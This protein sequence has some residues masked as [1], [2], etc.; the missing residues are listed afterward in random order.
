MLLYIPLI[1]LACGEKLLVNASWVTV[2]VCFKEENL[3]KCMLPHETEHFIVEI[4]FPLLMENRVFSYLYHLLEWHD[5]TFFLSNCLVNDKSSSCHCS[6]ECL[7]LHWQK[8]PSIFFDLH[9]GLLIVMKNIIA[10]ASVW[11]VFL[12]HV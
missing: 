1:G 7:N 8:K 4:I 9:L 11:S 5:G 2:N 3:F 6:L 12:L 10:K